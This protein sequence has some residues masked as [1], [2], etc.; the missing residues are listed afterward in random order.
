MHEKLLT[1]YH[2]VSF[3][4]RVS[5]AY[6]T[7]YGA[8][9]NKATQVT[10]FDQEWRSHICTDFPK[11]AK[12]STTF[13]LVFLSLLL[14]MITYPLLIR[15]LFFLF[16]LAKKSL[17]SWFFFC[18]LNS[19]HWLWFCPRLGRCSLWDFSGCSHSAQRWCYAAGCS[20]LQLRPVPTGPHC[21]CRLLYVLLYILVFSC[22]GEMKAGKEVDFHRSLP[23]S[24]DFA[25][26]AVLK[27]SRL[28]VLS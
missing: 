10:E 7:Y 19:D 22:M 14:R 6:C 3:N 27:L 8:V 15:S 20:L 2:Q 12:E 21:L 1:P 11:D 28:N 13:K 24:E 26:S 17:H 25:F 9:H 5:A 16:L 4:Q 18:F 23:H